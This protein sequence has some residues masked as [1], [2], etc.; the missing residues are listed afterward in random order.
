M[1]A[2]P[3]GYSLLSTPSILHLRCPPMAPVRC[4]PKLDPCLPFRVLC[5]W[6]QQS[7]QILLL[8]QHT[9]SGGSRTAR[10]P[11][12][13]AHWACPIP[14]PTSFIPGLECP[15]TPSIPGQPLQGP[16]PVTFL[17]SAC[18]SRLTAFSSQKSFASSLAFQS[19]QH[20]LVTACAVS[21]SQQE[22]APGSEP[23]SQL[24]E[25]AALQN[26]VCSKLSLTQELA[27]LSASLHKTMEQSQRPAGMAASLTFSVIIK[28]IS[29]GKLEATSG[30]NPGQ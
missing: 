15:L 12:N 17:A 16:R 13:M 26:S 8:P 11:M 4:H 23:V 6:I 20:H 30:P 22:A 18:S 1:G 10:D 2:A 24:M 27:T 14:T 5:S 3:S 19:R 9:P 7:F 28:I 29:L 21:H 25:S